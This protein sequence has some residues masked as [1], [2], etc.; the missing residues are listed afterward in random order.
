[1]VGGVG[2]GGDANSRLYPVIIKSRRILKPVLEMKHGE[3]TFKEIF[4]ERFKPEKNAEEK[5]IGLVQGKVI[6]IV[7]DRNSGVTTLIVTYPDPV[8]AAAF[9]NALLQQLDHFFNYQY[10][11][12]ASL[13]KRLLESRLESVTDSL[14]IGEERLADFLNRNRS[15]EHSPA[16]AIREMRLR[17]DMEVQST[18]YKE[19]LRQRESIKFNELSAN[20]VLNILDRAVPAIEKFAPIRRKYAAISGIVAVLAAMAILKLRS[21]A[22]RSPGEARAGSSGVA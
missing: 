14:R 12:A 6:D 15:Y 9:A 22:V 17:R 3:R 4:K 11:S 20:P 18:L 10:Q 7:V 5:L 19:L 2:A 13:Q 21:M 1:L 16:L 8:V